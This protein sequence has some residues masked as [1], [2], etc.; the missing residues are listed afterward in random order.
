MTN[1]IF[2]TKCQAEFSINFPSE[3]LLDSND[4]HIY[5]FRCYIPNNSGE[6]PAPVEIENNCL[7]NTTTLSSG[8]VQP[9]ADLTLTNTQLNSELVMNQTAEQ[10]NMLM[11]KMNICTSMI[12]EHIDLS[13]HDSAE[14][15]SVVSQIISDPEKHTTLNIPQTPELT[16]RNLLDVTELHL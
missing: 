13:A 3:S 12:H 15:P 10:T 11:L 14:H 5:L 9:E 1:V 16:T 2:S 8:L 4:T 6:K 7:E